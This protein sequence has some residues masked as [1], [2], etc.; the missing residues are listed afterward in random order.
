MPKVLHVNYSNAGGAGVACQRTSD[1]IAY[2][3]DWQSETFFAVR[4][5][6]W[7]NPFSDILAAVTAAFDN[8][9]VKKHASVS[10]L[11]LFRRSSRAG[12]LARKIEAG[13][14]DIIHL[15][16]VEGLLTPKVVSSILNSGA[17]VVMTLHDMRPF[18]GACHYSGTC[19]QY[20]KSCASYPLARHGFHS[21]IQKNQNS[22]LKLIRRLSPRLITPDQWMMNRLPDEFKPNSFLIPNPMP[23]VL[24]QTASVRTDDTLII[25][26]LAANLGDPIKNLTATRDYVTAL[27]V[28]GQNVIL[29][30]AGDNCPK[31]LQPWE[32]H[33]GTLAEDKK[34]EWLVSLDYL[35]F[36]SIH[37]NSPLVIQE[38]LACGT[39]VLFE[40]GTGADE[41]LDK[42]SGIPWREVTPKLLETKDNELFC[43]ENLGLLNLGNDLSTAA[44]LI[45]VYGQTG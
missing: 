45:E 2:L 19:D 30:L 33:A 39:P 18:T 25:G 10:P 4:H 1:E 26:F 12:R 24:E 23:K 6:L 13:G 16:W 41:M 14:Y 35:S 34:W 5:S 32:R 8:F 36:T 27:R 31:N 20:W 42:K 40:P 43:G 3:P 11:S 15:H 9:V 22:H 29:E 17:K 37:D 7:A 44:K 28:Q 21:S 38:T